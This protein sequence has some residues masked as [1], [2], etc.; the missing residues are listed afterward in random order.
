MIRVPITTTLDPTIVKLLDARAG[1]EKRTR[2]ALVEIILREALKPRERRN[3]QDD[4][5]D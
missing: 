5:G 3:A 2:S 1:R 4:S